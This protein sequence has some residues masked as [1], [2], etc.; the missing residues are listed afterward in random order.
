MKRSS[1]ASGSGYVP[2]CSIGF[3]VAS[4]KNGSGS[5]YVVPAGGDLV[6][7]HRL[8]QRGLRLRRRAVDFVGEDHVREDRPRQEHEP[9]PARLGV[10]LQDVGAGDVGRHQ[11]GRE[12]DALEREVQDLRDGAD[13]Q[14]LGQARHADEQAVPAANMAMSSCSTTVFW[15]TMTL[16]ICSDIR[17]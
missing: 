9:P 12:L 13:E 1:C 14:R 6:L 10:V 16:P 15:P 11:V 2:S 3:C 8:E 5:W 4:T 17:S 7:L